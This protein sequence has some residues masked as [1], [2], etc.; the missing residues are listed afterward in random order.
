MRQKAS[1]KYH[2]ES[3]F[4]SRMQKANKSTR[5]PNAKR[6]AIANKMVAMY[7]GLRAWS[8]CYTR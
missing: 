3:Q 2:D 5:I 4:F 8:V 1:I 7:S 6:L